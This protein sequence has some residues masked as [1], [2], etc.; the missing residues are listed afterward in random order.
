MV[1][2]GVNGECGARPGSYEAGKTYT[3]TAC[4]EAGQPVTEGEIKIYTTA[5]GDIDHLTEGS[6]VKTVNLAE[7][8]GTFQMTVQESDYIGAIADSGAALLIGPNPH[9]GGNDKG[10]DDKGGDNGSNGGAKNGGSKG[11]TGKSNGKAGNKGLP[12]T[13]L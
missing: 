4:N 7:T 6:L 2:F 12:K 10:G 9:Q 5:N 13:G 3:F 8:G 1:D 11:Q